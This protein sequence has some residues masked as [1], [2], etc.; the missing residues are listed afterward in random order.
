MAEP[1]GGSEHEQGEER[2]WIARC[3]AGETDAFRPLV[4]R[5]ARMVHGMIARL[6]PAADVED[7]AQQTFLSAFEH[8]DQYAE[9]ARFSTWLCQIAINKA[10]D[11]RRAAR[12]RPESEL[13]DDYEDG[14]SDEGPEECAVSRESGQGLQV[15]LAQLGQGDRELLVLKYVLEESYETVARILGA[16]VGATKVRALRA[17]ER[18]RQILNKDG[19]YGKRE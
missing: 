18:L 7:L 11:D 19:I 1:V 4:V 5:Y 2:E 16:S 14:K 12:R 13:L 3:R 8:L 10:R 6:S 9:G 17:R 15:A